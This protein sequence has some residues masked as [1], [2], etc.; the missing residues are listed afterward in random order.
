MGALLSVSK[1]LCIYK[2]CLT[3]TFFTVFIFLLLHLLLPLY[4]C[5]CVSY[6]RHTLLNLSI[7]ITLSLSCSLSLPL[8]LARRSSLFSLS[9]LR[10]KPLTLIDYP[11]DATF[12]AFIRARATFQR[13]LRLQFALAVCV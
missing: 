1:D 6:A 13:V 4:T 2:S 3:V 8:V 7:P 5:C 11:L 10:L 12:V 9:W